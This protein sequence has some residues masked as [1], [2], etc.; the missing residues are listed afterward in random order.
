MVELLVDGWAQPQATSVASAS[1]LRF[2]TAVVVIE[3]KT[4]GAHVFNPVMIRDVYHH[5]S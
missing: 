2:R 1:Q 3:R 5:A 4:R